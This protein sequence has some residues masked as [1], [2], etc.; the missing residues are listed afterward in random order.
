VIE[1]TGIV[2]CEVFVTYSGAPILNEGRER[3]VVMRNKGK[4]NGEEKIVT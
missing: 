2:I 3:R 4:G 1:T